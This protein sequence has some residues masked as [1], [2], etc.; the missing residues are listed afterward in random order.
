MGVGAKQHLEILKIATLNAV[1][2]GRKNGTSAKMEHPPN[3][4][5]SEEASLGCT[6]K[7]LH[8][9]EPLQDLCSDKTGDMPSYR[10]LGTPSIRQIPLSP[11]SPSTRALLNTR[12]VQEVASTLVQMFAASVLA[13]CSGKDIKPLS[14]SSASPLVFLKLLSKPPLIHGGSKQ[15][16]SIQPHTNDRSSIENSVS[17]PQ[18]SN[19]NAKSHPHLTRQCSLLL[20]GKAYMETQ[21]QSP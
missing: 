7:R 15:G 18:A 4:P 1:G 6:R 17:T 8:T 9:M 12:Y 16:R 10:V 11:T 19:T 21:Y 3:P 20:Q 5:P 13:W 14:C 2:V